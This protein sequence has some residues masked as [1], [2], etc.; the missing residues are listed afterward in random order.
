MKGPDSRGGGG[1]IGLA[2][3]IS[4]PAIAA[5]HET[6]KLSVG[7]SATFWPV[8]FVVLVAGAGLV[9]VA[10]ALSGR[11]IWIRL[12]AALPNGLVLMFYGFF[13]LFFGLGGS[14]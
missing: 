10:K 7:P 11:S 3:S 8:F 9:V 6:G 5:L 14:R 4:G 13:L 1:F 2:A 12:L